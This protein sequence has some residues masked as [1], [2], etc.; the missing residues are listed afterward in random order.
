MRQNLVVREWTAKVRRLIKQS[1]AQF[2]HGKSGSVLRDGGSRPEHKL[3]PTIK[4]K[5]NYEHGISVGAS[6]RFERHGVFVHKGVGRGYQMQGGMVVRTAKNPP[7]PRPRV[8]VDWFNHIIDSSVPELAERVG[9]IN[10]D[11]A[12]NAVR[13]RI[14]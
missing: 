3:Q 8:P 13:M 6:F 2:Q 1:T 5:V 10:A 14:K 7:N 11:A 4:G 12:I 9:R